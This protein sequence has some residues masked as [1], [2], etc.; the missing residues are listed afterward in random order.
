MPLVDSDDPHD[1]LAADDLALGT[2]GLDGS[3]DLHGSPGREEARVSTHG[4]S[5]RIAIVCSKWADRLRSFVTAVHSSS[6]TSTSE[7]PAFTIGSTAMT[8][9]VFMRFPVPAS[10]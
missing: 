5:S 3:A 9:P 2:D 7:A 6:S 10:P 1:A 4:P 8:R